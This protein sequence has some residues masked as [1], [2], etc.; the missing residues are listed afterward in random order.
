MLDSESLSGVDEDGGMD[1]YEEKMLKLRKTLFS[2]ANKNIRNAQDRQKR[3]YDKKHHRQVVSSFFNFNVTRLEV[4]VK[5][6]A[7]CYTCSIIHMFN[8]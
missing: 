2:K 1:K 4:S 7:G 5:L 3:D 8:I 6:V